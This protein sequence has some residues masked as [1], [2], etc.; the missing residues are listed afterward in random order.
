[1]DLRAPRL[2]PPDNF[3]KKLLLLLLLLLLLPPQHSI[4][5]SPLAGWLAAFCWPFLEGRSG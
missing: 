2:M 1:L 3:L 4:A 5:A